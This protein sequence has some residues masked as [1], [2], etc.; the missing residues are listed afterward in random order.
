MCKKSVPH[1]NSLFFVIFSYTS[2]FVLLAQQPIMRIFLSASLVG[3]LFVLRPS[4]SFVPRRIPI[5]WS[6]KIVPSSSSSSS[7]SS[8]SFPVLFASSSDG[9]TSGGTSGGSNGG[10]PNVDRMKELIK[11][12]AFDRNMMKASAEQMKNLTPDQIDAMIR[13]MDSMNIIQKQGM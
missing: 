6:R 4:D 12:E 2:T 11:E 9:G 1:H 7:S 10:L 5:E 13:E 3:L 8:A